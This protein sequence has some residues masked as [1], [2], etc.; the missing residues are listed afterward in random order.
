MSDVH[1]PRSIHDRSQ[2][3]YAALSVLMSRQQNS[4]MPESLYFLSPDQI[5]TFV[6]TYEGQTI[7]VPTV[8]EFGEDLMVALAAYYIYNQKVTPQAAQA[9]LNLTDARWRVIMNKL[10]R[11]QEYVQD[12]T[13]MDPTRLVAS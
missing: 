7:R 6:A 2:Y 10:A 12:E 4:I 8:K 11:W 1:I 13:A 9:K 3:F 5:L